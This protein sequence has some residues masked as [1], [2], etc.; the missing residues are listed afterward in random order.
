MK[1]HTFDHVYGSDIGQEEI[2][3]TVEKPPSEGIFKGFHATVLAYNQT[4]SGTTYSI[5]FA[6]KSADDDGESTDVDGKF[7]FHTSALNGL[8]IYSRACF[9]E[10]LT[11]HQDE[12]R[13]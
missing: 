2:Y 3:N 12:R 4:R 6:H 13:V 8:G 7:S 9:Q 10:I 5:G 1:I 11:H